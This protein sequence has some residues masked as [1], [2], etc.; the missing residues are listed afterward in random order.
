MK[1][2]KTPSIE[3][4]TKFNLYRNKFKTIRIN[5]ER[6]Y[7]A[8]E[9]CKHQNDL[10]TTWKL[11]KS[12]MHLDSQQEKIDCLVI[13]GLNITDAEQIA[14]NFNKYFVNIAK[15]L[16]VKLQASPSSF[17]SFMPPHSVTLWGCH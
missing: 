14:D 1:F 7:Y 4:K 11:I 3:N 17:E 13:N 6:L 5:A 10:K 9:F 12:A 2:L 8:T 16:A 15:D